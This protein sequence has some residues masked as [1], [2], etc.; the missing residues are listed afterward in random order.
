VWKL[1]VTIPGGGRVNRTVQGEADDARRQLA[2]L[3]VQQRGGAR[4]LDLLVSAHLAQLHDTGR[5]PDTL[6]RYQQQLRRQVRHLGDGASA[7][8]HSGGRPGHLIEYLDHHVSPA[9]VRPGSPTAESGSEAA[10]VKLKGN[11]AAKL[12]L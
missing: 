6:R 11:A 7:Q 8:Q 10:R 3:A 4:T 1:T 2:V 9:V 12:G 5:R